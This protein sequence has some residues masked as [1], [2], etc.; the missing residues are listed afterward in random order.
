MKCEN[1][2]FEFLK[3][4]NNPYKFLHSAFDYLRKDINPKSKS[5]TGKLNFLLPLVGGDYIINYIRH[6]RNCASHANR[7]SVKIRRI[8]AKLCLDAML[9][10]LKT[11]K[12]NGILEEILK[13]DDVYETQ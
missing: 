5:S 13:Q 12:D 6:M 1:E 4:E 3:Y 9:N 7:A 11:F 2:N 8:D 10:L